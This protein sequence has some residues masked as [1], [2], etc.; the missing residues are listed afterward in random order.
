[1]ICPC[2]GQRVDHEDPDRIAFVAGLQPKE[3]K[4]LAFVMEKSPD[5][6]P[7]DRLIWQLWGD[8]PDG[9]PDTARGTLHSKV[10]T[11]NR[12]LAPQG[13]RITAMTSGYREAG[14][15]VVPVAGLTP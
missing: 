2:C 3:A 8:D 15:V 9:G 10:S 6:V 7:I 14:Y 12:K 1:M 11:A 13:I 5:P 4:I